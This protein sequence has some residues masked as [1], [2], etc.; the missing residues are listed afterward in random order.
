MTRAPSDAGMD[1]IPEAGKM[2]ERDLVRE[3][4]TELR[5]TKAW[6]A[7]F[8]PGSAEVLVR[9]VLQAMREPTPGMLWAHELP[10]VGPDDLKEFWQAAIDAALRDGEG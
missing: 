10:H 6:P 5:A 7:F 3:I 1:H 2:V 4:A 9:F 8:M